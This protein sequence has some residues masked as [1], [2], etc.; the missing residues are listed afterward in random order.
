MALRS[1]FSTQISMTEYT[2]SLGLT[3]TC[4]LETSSVQGVY[5]AGVAVVLGLLKLRNRS[6]VYMCQSFA[7]IYYLVEYTLN[8]LE[9]LFPLVCVEL[10]KLLYQ[11]GVATK[12]HFKMKFKWL[13]I[14]N[15]ANNVIR[16]ECIRDNFVL[17]SAKV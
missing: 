13:L 1:Y 3:A 6:K 12:Y 14:F 17:I 4:Y 11:A 15:F 8:D 10:A 9:L 2:L 7:I 16:V 5:H